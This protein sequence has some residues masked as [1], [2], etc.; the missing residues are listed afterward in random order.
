MLRK[1]HTTP[2]IVH[3]GI[4]Q[5]RFFFGEKYKQYLTFSVEITTNTLIS[6]Y[7]ENAWNDEKESM[8]ESIKSLHD[9]G[10]NYRTIAELLNAEGSRT[11]KNKE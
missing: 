11:A 9:S 7:N 10:K 1:T 2:Q 8:Y 5:N 4:S 3:C 6:A